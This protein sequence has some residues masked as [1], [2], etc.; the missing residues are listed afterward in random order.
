MFEIYSLGDG[1]FMKRTLDAVALMSNEGFLLMLGGFGLLLGLLSTGFKA[2]ES[3][4]QKIELPAI[5]VSFLLI[6]AMFTVKVD[7]TVYSMNGAPGQ[8][9]FQ[10]Y[11]VDN[12]PAGVAVPASIVSVAG[13][14]ITEKMQQAFAVPGMEDVGLQGGQFGNTLKLIDMTRRWDLEGLRGN[15][16][17]VSS[18]KTNLRNYYSDCTIPGIK[19]GA[20]DQNVL[21][22]SANPLSMHGDAGGIGFSDKWTSTT[23]IVAGT[24]LELDCDVAMQRLIDQAG[25]EGMLK[26]FLDSAMKLTDAR[27]NAPDAPNAVDSAFAAINLGST[28]IQSHVMASAVR[29]IMDE[30]VIGSSSLTPQD[31]QAQLMLI[32]GNRQR[33]DEWGAGEIM[34]RKA[35]RPFMAFLECIVFIAAPFMALMAGL[36][37]FGHRV[38]AKYLMVTLWV[39]TWGPM[40]A[41]VE[42]FQITMVQHA[43]RAMELLQVSSGGVP[44]SSIAGAAALNSELTTWISVGGWMATLVPPMGYLLLSGGAVAM[45]SFAGRLAG[46]DHINEKMTSPDLAKMGEIMSISSRMSGSNA[47]GMQMSGVESVAGK[48]NSGTAL[49]DQVQA[50]SSALQTA[51]KTFQSQVANAFTAALGT[52]QNVNHESSRGESVDSRFTDSTGTTNGVSVSTGVGDE[53]TRRKEASKGSEVGFNGELGA[54]GKMQGDADLNGGSKGGGAEGE[55]KKGSG[56]MAGHLIGGIGARAQS[57]ER[58]SDASG[59]GNSSHISSE[60]RAGLQRAREASTTG[61]QIEA[62][63]SMAANGSS[64]AKQMLETL[65]NSQAFQDV[66]AATRAHQ[67]ATSL[68]NSAAASNG[69]DIAAFSYQLTTR[70]GTDGGDRAYAAAIENGGYQA[71]SA[72]MDHVN[73]MR[74]GPN[75]VFTGTDEQARNLASLMTLAGTGNGSHLLT[76][77]SEAERFAAFAGLVNDYSVAVAGGSFGNPR[78][79]TDV[80]AGAPEYGAATAAASG[81]QTGNIPDASLEGAV[82]ADI[83]AGSGAD[84]ASIKRHAAIADAQSDPEA[85]ALTMTALFK[86]EAHHVR[87]EG[88]ENLKDTMEQTVRTDILNAAGAVTETASQGLGGASLFKVLEK[89]VGAEGSHLQRDDSRATMSEYMGDGVTRFQEIRE[90]VANS[91]GLS[92]GTRDENMIT[93][94]AAAKYLAEESLFGKG[95]AYLTFEDATQI[96]QARESKGSDIRFPTYQE[97]ATDAVGLSGTGTS[98]NGNAGLNFVR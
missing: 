87:Q 90:Q 41:A 46:G 50:T 37:S 55:G 18:F 16:S 51:T 84:I 35:M 33:Q 74:S 45:T 40:F 48:F 71:F 89:P 86:N 19:R 80:A 47:G 39:T 34:F 8:T 23:I 1:L 43:V 82:K 94:T 62:L 7:V 61:Q 9:Q 10:T 13:K 68:A 93:L 12:V 85:R 95:T 63:R 96:E 66:Q 24:P 60:E 20:I 44:L 75:P 67:E 30:A 56:K 69:I 58:S 32:Q 59:W 38:V 77:D 27:S 6:I 28:A 79:N 36:G 29:E 25:D 88:Q 14:N 42:L 91:T 26:D 15:Q 83:A 81:I 76:K 73:A 64:I 78:A 97:V 11:T 57:T 49:Q 17:K 21:L 65:T 70:G 5:L 31:I 22:A 92:E 2:I 53:A 52:S 98:T 4:M 54:A 3:G 72:N